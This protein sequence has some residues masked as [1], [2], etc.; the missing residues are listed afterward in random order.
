MSIA[1]HTDRQKA[2]HENVAKSLRGLADQI[3]A[4]EVTP[5]E[6]NMDS[7][8][9]HFAPP[10]SVT[11][12]TIHTGEMTL[13]FTYE[14]RESVEQYWAKVEQYGGLLPARF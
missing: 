11:Y 10:G 4:G 2:F 3:E 7:P 6:W 13:G 12:D 1:W 9:A 8:V 14:I 5:R